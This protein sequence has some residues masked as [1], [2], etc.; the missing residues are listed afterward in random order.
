M[1]LNEKEINPLNDLIVGY[2][3]Y[4]PN[5]NI[6]NDNIVSD[7]PNS[8]NNNNDYGPNLN[9]N[10]N[11]IESTQAVFVQTLNLQ[12]QQL[13]ELL[14]SKNKDFDGLNTQN[15]KLKLLLIQEQKKIIEKENNLHSIKIQ[16]KNL[17]ERINKN[18]I[19][20]ENMK[21]KIKELNYKLI[22]L[23]QNMISKENIYQFNNKIKDILEKEN[24]GND[25]QKQNN[26]IISEK[27]EIELKRLNNIIDELEIKNNK[28]IFDNKTLN[29]RITTIMNDKNSE[30]SVYKSIYQNQINNLKKIII[31]LTNRISQLFAEKDN[32]HILKNNNNLMKKEIMDKF[33]E[34]ENKLN[35]YD[36]ENCKLRKENQTIK[37]ELEEL[38]LINESKEKIIEKLQIDFGIMEKKYNNSLLMSRKI[39]ESSKIDGMDK[40]RYINEL[41]NNQKNMIKD[42]NNLKMGLKQMTKNINEAN[43]LYFK[44]KAEYDKSLQARDNKLKE[45]K[46]K[47]TLLK[48]KI[49]ELHQ[50]INILKEYKGED[51][52]NSNNNNKNYYSFLTQ[53]NNDNKNKNKKDQK[54][55][56]TFTPKVRKSIPFEFNLENK[57][58]HNNGN[59]DGNDIFGDIKISEVPK[60]NNSIK[61]ASL[62]G[63]NNYTG[64]EK[65]D[66]NNKINDIDKL[67]NNEQDLKFIQEYKDT[68]NKIDEQ[69]KKLNS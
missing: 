39:D 31:N 17:E 51:C 10:D 33:T 48:M 47:I 57:K 15:N 30:L 69:L 67:A 37:N 32:Q 45:Y 22:E 8:F 2:N 9:G 29:S 28:L 52:L 38:K 60:D 46:T 5:E 12:I 16:K 11:D 68:L 14:K 56:I 4:A 50:E 59:V 13:Q 18:V 42:N 35:N 1:A 55:L 20:S 61:H 3:N 62:K 44:K 40:S 41:I 27:Y 6:D 23:N 24:T 64:Q 7:N 53:N 66:N 43:Q 63:N 34:L 36:K 58:E 25:E 26:I 21:A 49:N 19:D 54:K 65:N